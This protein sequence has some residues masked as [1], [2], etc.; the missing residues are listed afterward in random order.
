MM[1][2]IDLP[3][4]IFWQF[5]WRLRQRARRRR[6]GPAALRMLSLLPAAGR[7]LFRN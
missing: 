2:L 1:I 6:R 5:Q 7:G 3:P 4:W